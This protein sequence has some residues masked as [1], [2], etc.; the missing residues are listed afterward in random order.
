MNRHVVVIP[1]LA[2][3]EVILT[4]DGD[5]VLSLPKTVVDEKEKDL[6]LCASSCLRQQTGFESKKFL[7]LAS[8]AH[9]E[10]LRTTYFVAVA[11]NPSED[12][13]KFSS[14]LQLEPYEQTVLLAKSGVLNMESSLG[15]FLASSYANR[16]WS[17]Q[18]PES[19]L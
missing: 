11:L 4:H 9:S 16:D 12:I 7:G 2:T 3:G 18:T 8:F 5:H 6:T 10:N 19:T 17:S 15:I 14:T 13:Q 1:L